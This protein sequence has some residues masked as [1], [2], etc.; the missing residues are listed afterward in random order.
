LP[1]LI[2]P[3]VTIVISPLIALMVC[4][5]FF[6]GDQSLEFDQKKERKSA[7]VGNELFNLSC[8]IKLSPIAKSSRFIETTE[9]P[10]QSLKFHSH[11]NAAST[12]HHWS[13]LQN[14]QNKTPLCMIFD[15]TF[16]PLYFI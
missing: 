2:F 12:C 6:S 8:G 15:L 14:T 16:G 1:A 10:C 9:Y 7:S 11:F 4:T 3:G 13:P 5:I